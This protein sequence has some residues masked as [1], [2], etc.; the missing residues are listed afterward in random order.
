MELE[1]AKSVLE[2]LLFVAGEP[3]PVGKLAQ[4]LGANTSLVE[5]ALSALAQVCE[6][7]GL[8]IQ[9]HD[10]Q[11]QMVTAPNAAPYIERFLGLQFSGRLSTASLETL[12]IIAYKQ[13]VTRAQI[14]AIRG[15]NSEGVLRSLLAKGLVEERDREEVPGR[16]ILYGTT[17]EFLQQF[18][19]SHLKELPKLKED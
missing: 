10:Q 3:V 8:R 9:R 16:P 19:L 13:P 1:E 14:E 4:A 18:G 11:V 2:A 7:R 15:V 6:G 17:F 5:E 12:A